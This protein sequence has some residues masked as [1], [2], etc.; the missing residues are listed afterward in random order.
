DESRT[1]GIAQ[2][3]HLRQQAE[4][5][6][7]VP[8]RSLAD[9]VAPKSSGVP[10]YIGAFAVSAGF[11]CAEK[12]AEFRQDNDDYNA[13]LLESLADR[14]AEALAERMHQ[15]VRKEYWGYVPDER[16]TKVAL[17]SEQYTGIR[18]APG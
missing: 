7:G 14:L 11:G 15:R 4:H 18:P 16:Q 6:E 9:F 13:I 2:L 1:R 5:R 17:I 8:H 3:F 12:T 10:D